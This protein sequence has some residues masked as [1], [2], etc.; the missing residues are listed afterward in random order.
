MRE[1]LGHMA[2]AFHATHCIVERLPKPVHQTRPDEFRIRGFNA[3]ATIGVR[4]G[5]ELDFDVLDHVVARYGNP[6]P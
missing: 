3:L 2:A 4:H 5:I 6:R 1:Q